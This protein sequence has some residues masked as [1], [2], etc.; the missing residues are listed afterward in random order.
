MD[1]KRRDFLSM[2]A[3]SLGT[4]AALREVSA[5]DNLSEESTDQRSQGRTTLELGPVDDPSITTNTIAE[6]EKL[7]AVKFTQT[8]RQMMLETLGT[9]LERFK[10]RQTYTLPNNLATATRFDPRLPGTTTK[11]QNNRPFT[12]ILLNCSTE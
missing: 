11:E 7:A 1:R 6:A 2:A 12:A 4:A 5:Q 8:E 9:Q 3:A 10:E